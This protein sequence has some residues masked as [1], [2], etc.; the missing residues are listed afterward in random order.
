MKKTKKK[1]VTL[2]KKM[3]N[4]Y[5]LSLYA[6]FFCSMEA[7]NMSYLKK[8]EISL[9]P[10]KYFIDALGAMALGLFASLLIGTIFGTLADYVPNIE[11]RKF[12]LNMKEYAVMAQGPAMAIAIG[13][14]L[15]ASGLLL[16]SLCA[17]GAAGNA[18]GG[19][20]GTY[21]AVLVSCELGKLV[22]KTTK[23]DIIVT[24][25]VVIGLGVGVSLALGPG[26]SSIM[27]YLGN[28]I[29]T[30]TEMQPLLMGALV[31]VVVGICLTLPIS[32]AA[33]C[34]MLSLTGIAGG[35]ATA[36]CCAQ[37]VGFAVMSFSANRWGGLIAQGLGTSM[38]QMGNIVKKPV[39][40]IPPIIT[41]AITGALSAVVFKMENPVAIASGMGTCGLVGPIGVLSV[42]GI[43]TNEITAVILIC[44][45]L[46]GVLTWLIAKPFKKCGLIKDY[47]LKLDI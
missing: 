43:G 37:M 23:I 36:G 15:N 10:K 12:L 30:F 47:D 21:V 24:P 40:W 17:V 34:A 42:K 16:F 22:Y 45:V 14:A 28:L 41:S 44:F 3:I 5:I 9:S 46:P 8:K 27:T 32:S 25:T 1:N 4:W 20:L 19:P 29:M 13:S 33:I 7:L 2:L 18:L 6:E 35:A 26:I 39:I 11:A 38:L 31:S